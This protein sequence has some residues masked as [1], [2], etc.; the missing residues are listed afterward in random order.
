MSSRAVVAD[1]LVK[2]YPVYRSPVDR[3]LALASARRRSE[4]RFVALRGVSFALES[5]ECL[6]LIGE[7]GA[8]KSTL[9][10]IVAGV[11]QPTSGTIAVH[12]R[13]A[14]ILELG[15]GFHPDFTGRQNIELNA[16]MLGLEPEEVREKLPGIIAFAEIGDFIDRPVRQYSSG[17]AMRL[18]FAIA[19]QVDPDVL[20]VDEALAVG[21]GYFQKK[22]MDRIQAFR[23][24]GRSLLFCSH[25]L[26]YVAAYCDKTVWM[27]DGRVEAA[28]ETRDVVQ[29][30]EA[31][32]L[33]RES[34]LDRAVREE[35]SASTAAAPNETRLTRVA[36]SGGEPRESAR[37]Y[38]SRAPWAVD[39]EW[40]SDD[41]ERGF[42]LGVGIDL[43]NG[44][45]IASFT[46]RRD[47]AEP[48]RGARRYRA[49]FEIPSLPLVKGIY[50]TIVFLGDEEAL[51]IYDRRWLDE[52]FVVTGGEFSHGL[53]DAE[54]EWR[55]EAARD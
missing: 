45:C 18:A 46:S 13:V 52:A 9:L 41:P 29:Q 2:S 15:S 23:Q 55:V 1:A 27:R 5:G 11:T 32:L 3:L 8:G 51:H 42:H 43:E 44:L 16:A 50:K 28:G 26:Y 14:A 35:E 22:C 31:Y 39:I 7:N 4:R 24:R 53:L 40:I 33:R 34:G 20:I 6:G 17:M 38:S 19:V 49:R 36:L 21:D 25:A 48:F 10:K 12:G 30:Y 54:H 37:G 47:G